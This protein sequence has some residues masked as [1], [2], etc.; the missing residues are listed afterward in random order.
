[1]APQCHT[2]SVA[3]YPASGCQERGPDMFVLAPPPTPCP[4][5]TWLAEAPASYT[6]ISETVRGGSE[7]VPFPFRIMGG[8]LPAMPSAAAQAEAPGSGNEQASSSLPSHFRASAAASL[9]HFFATR[10][11]S[12]RTSQDRLVFD[13]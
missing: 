13:L 3:A 7:Q 6:P 11:P 1:M 4:P 5:S 12:E 9:Q 8:A 10:E 2:D